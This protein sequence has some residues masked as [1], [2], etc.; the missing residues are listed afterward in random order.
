MGTA[1]VPRC[2]SSA[3]RCRGECAFLAG[4]R[5]DDF[6]APIASKSNRLP[7]AACNTVLDRR[8]Q[9]L[10]DSIEQPAFCLAQAGLFAAR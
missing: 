4:L 7:P 8:R 5:S 6:E 10:H 9:E 2:V 3:F 1:A